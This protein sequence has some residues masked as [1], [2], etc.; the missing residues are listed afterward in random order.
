[1]ASSTSQPR[2]EAAAISWAT[3]SPS[4]TPSIPTRAGSTGRRSTTLSHAAAST[5]GGW[6]RPSP[7]WSTALRQ[8]RGADRRQRDAHERRPRL[9]SGRARAQRLFAGEQPGDLR[10]ASARPRPTSGSSILTRSGFAGQQRYGAAVVVGRHHV[11]LDGAAQ[12]DPGRARLLDLGRAVLDHGHRR[13][14]GAL[15][16]SPRTGPIAADL[17]EWRELDDALVRVRD[18]PADPARARRVARAR[19][20]AVRRR[21]GGGAG[22][23][24]YRPS[25]SSTACATGCCRTSTRWPAR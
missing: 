23:P 9:G 15:T 20:V 25:S 2:R 3:S 24:A 17:D 8:P 21:G 10:R 5:P 6:T 22:S 1:M 4:T 14:L 7:R 11:D 13:L 19:D 12:A 18:V 16:A